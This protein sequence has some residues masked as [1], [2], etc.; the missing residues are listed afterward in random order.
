MLQTHSR[1]RRKKIPIMAGLAIV[2]GLIF[3]MA[4]NAGQV[5]AAACP[6]S[7]NIMS[8]GFNGRQD[9]LD[10]VQNNDDG[11]GHNDLQQ[12]FNQF[13]FSNSQADRDNF[14]NNGVEGV[15]K[16]N[17]DIQVDG[18][19]VAHNASSFGRTR[20]CQGSEPIQE[21]AIPGTSTT[22]FGN[23]NAQTLVDDNQQV[24]AMFDDTGTLQFAVLPSCGN[25]E[26]FVPVKSNFKCDL[27]HSHPVDNQANTFT[28]TTDLTVTG[29]AKLDHVE[30]NFG[31]GSP[32]VSVPNGDTPTPPH[33]FTQTST[34]TSTVF[35]T[36]PG[37]KQPVSNTSPTCETTITVKPPTPPVTPVTPT[38][39]P[40]LPNTGAGNVIGLFAGVTLG[41]ALVARWIQLRRQQGS[42]L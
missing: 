29:L 23:T 38:V 40:V 12:I 31:D 39:P 6:P 22:I 26:K 32:V 42:S 21:M 17:G 4:L 30:Y 35:V 25:A 19:T 10:K 3:G 36:L 33:T 5:G 27:I 8:G 16:Q 9:F 13:G 18:V 15:A 24:I 14:L 34:V 7:N 11:A 1:A 20:E 28:F 41:G 37:H 2:L